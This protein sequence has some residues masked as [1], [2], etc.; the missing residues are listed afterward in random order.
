M[1]L[2]GAT[3]I[4]F[5]V[6]VLG[7]NQRLGWTLTANV[8]PGATVYDVQETAGGYRFDRADCPFELREESVLVRMSGGLERRRWTVRHT[9]HGL[10][11]SPANRCLALRLTGLDQPRTLHQ[12]W[13]MA[14]AMDLPAFEAA[15]AQMQ[16]PAFSVIYADADGHILYFSG[17]LVPVWPTGVAPAS[18][19]PAPGD[20]SETLWTDIHRFS[21]LP[22]LLDP[23][24]GWLQNANDPPWSATANGG[25]SPDDFP[26]YMAPRGPIS[27][28]AQWSIRYLRRVE[29]MSLEDLIRAGM[30]L[31]AELADRV[32]DTLL[33][34]CSLRGG[35]S[36]TEAARILATWDRTTHADSLGGVLFAAWLA[37]MGPEMFA[38]SWQ[39][40]APFETPRG[41]ADPEGATDILEAAYDDLIARFGRADMPWGAYFVMTTSGRETGACGGDIPLGVFRELWFDD[42][43]DGRKVARGGTG[44][45]FAV[46]FTSPPRVQ[47][48][49]L[50]GNAVPAWAAETF[51][52][53]ADLFSAGRLRTVPMRRE[54]VEAQC[55][56]HQ[57]I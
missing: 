48:L 37:R 57:T 14:C 20:R 54:D 24:S 47:A 21:D 49:N 3:L 55:V 29:A 38:E 39:E 50:M 12:W 15:L 43:A 28:R 17:G 41:L 51:A 26:A 56:R 16:V 22:R 40:E 2:Y 6:L 1:S 53:Q 10:V 44:L 34:A 9:R 36:L 32:I 46:E 13:S 30:S 45:I 35:N 42:A 33:A 19:R 23:E 8:Q 5:P 4:G 7:A 11:L 18:D 25:L 31:H 27:L 52:G